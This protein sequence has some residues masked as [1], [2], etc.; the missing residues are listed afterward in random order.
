MEQTHA[1]PSK[2]SSQAVAAAPEASD[3]I[4]KALPLPRT[5]LVSA[6][7]AVVIGRGLTHGL[8]GIST[9]MDSTIR[10]VEVVGAVLTQFS[11]LVLVTLCARLIVLLVMLQRH[12]G[13]VVLSVFATGAASV[14]TFLAALSNHVQLAPPFSVAVSALVVLAL[15]GSG[16]LALQ[17]PA[18]RAAGLVLLAAA[19]A[20]AAHTAARL[21]ALLASEAANAA[22]FNVSRV[23]STSGFFLEMLCLTACISWL[24]APKVVWVRAA[25]AVV[26][27]CSPALALAADQPGE[28]QLALRRTLE[29]LSAH[30][31]PLLPAWL[32]R[33]GE[34][35]AIGA[36]L[37]SASVFRRSAA[38]CLAA[39]MAILGRSSP[40]VPLGAMFLL[41]AALSMQLLLVP[42]KPA[43]Q[44]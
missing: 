19:S 15:V 21:V 38:L 27:V 28:W 37:L 23:I 13:L 4:S 26:V 35:L 3:L 39:G 30:P 33:S 16:A 5:M 12:I 11:A 20:A 6:L 36:T 17:V 31:D 1:S 8:P 9:G 10:V 43:D 18:K 34:V 32:Q 40:D 25:A 22:W 42:P 7:L 44:P 14:A 24:V 2:R 41:T 29:Q